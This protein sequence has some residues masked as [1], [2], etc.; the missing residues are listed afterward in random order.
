[1]SNLTYN[2][3]VNI[4]NNNYNNYNNNNN[5]NMDFNDNGGN[6]KASNTKF[7]RCPNC[8]FL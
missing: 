6:F 8:K 4:P 1:M 5:I 3:N 7:S 2:P